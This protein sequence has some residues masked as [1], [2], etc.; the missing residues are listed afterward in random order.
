M[1]ECGSLAFGIGSLYV[2][3]AV[4]YVLAWLTRPRLV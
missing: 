1:L 2:F 3:G 4:L